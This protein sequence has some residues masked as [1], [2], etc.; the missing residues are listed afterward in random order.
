MGSHNME[1]GGPGQ[2]VAGQSVTPLLPSHPHSPPPPPSPSPDLES[3]RTKHPSA[4]PS[5]LRVATTNSPTH[6]PIAIRVS[7]SPIQRLGLTSD[8]SPSPPAQVRSSHT[9]PTAPQQQVKAE[10]G[11]SPLLRRPTWPSTKSAFTAVPQGQGTPP[12]AQTTPT[13]PKATPPQSSSPTGSSGSLTTVPQTRP[14]AI[15]SQ[16]PSALEGSNTIEI[17]GAS[18]LG[19]ALSA[20]VPSTGSLKAATELHTSAGHVTQVTPTTSAAH[21]ASGIA[22]ANFPLAPAELSLIPSSQSAVH[23]LRPVPLAP[24]VTGVNVVA[25]SCGMSTAAFV[26]SPPTLTSPPTAVTSPP[27]TTLTPSHTPGPH[28]SPPH[29]G[30][31]TPRD[32]TPLPFSPSSA[33]GQFVG[34]SFARHQARYLGTVSPLTPLTP[35][36]YGSPLTSPLKYNNFYGSATCVATPTESD[37]LVRWLKQHRLHKYASLFEALSFEELCALSEEELKERG[38]TAGAAKKLRLKLDELR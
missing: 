26:V 20:P 18:S 29:S 35:Y 24:G 3:G 11:V 16:Q 31:P 25:R 6:S 27:S 22:L 5:L 23:T 15:I 7:G 36:T 10:E 1:Q 17:A 30:P 21:T 37:S 12:P 28:P 19:H 9:L 4:P 14:L 13:P 34:A 2:P 38:M 8:L 32:H 33:H